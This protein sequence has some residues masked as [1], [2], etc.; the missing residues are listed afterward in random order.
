[1]HGAP[2][3]PEN[4][5]TTPH[6]LVLVLISLSPVCLSLF[7]CLSLSL[8]VINLHTMGVCKQ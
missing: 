6:G 8:S 3:V 1:M 2:F 5:T 7:V 4:G